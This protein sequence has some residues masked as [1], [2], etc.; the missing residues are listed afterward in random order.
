LNLCFV[1]KVVIMYLPVEMLVEI[2]VWMDEP[3][4]MLGC[5]YTMLRQ[6]DRFNRHPYRWIVA[7]MDAIDND[8]PSMLEWHVDYVRGNKAAVEYVITN[9]ILS[10]NNDKIIQKLYDLY[11]G[12]S[13]MCLTTLN[14]FM[15]TDFGVRMMD[16]N[17]T[18]VPIIVPTHYINL[19]LSFGT[20]DADDKPVIFHQYRE[21]ANVNNLKVVRNGTGWTMSK[22]DR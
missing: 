19:L 22:G 18:E 8:D 10:P 7:T 4:S 3:G 15:W 11:G 20:A 16:E 13:F 14:K 9:C 12:D 17:G 6:I 2:A 5:C 21:A 1:L